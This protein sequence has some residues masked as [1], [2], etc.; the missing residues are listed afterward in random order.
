MAPHGHRPNP[1]PHPARR[2]TVLLLCAV[3]GA[4]LVA[5]AV[6]LQVLDRGFLQR[7]GDLRSLRVIPIPAHRGMIT[8]RNGA[9]LAISTPMDSVC[10]DPRELGGDRAGLAHLAR[11]LDLNPVSLAAR[12]RADSTRQFMYID[13]QIP[14]EAG[15]RAAALDLPGVFL[16]REYKSYYPTGPVAA[17][18]VGF[19]NIDNVGQEGLELAYNKWL[20]GVPG[21][22]RV[23]EDRL[24]HVVQDVE[25]LRAPRPGKDLALSLD[26][27]IQYLAYRELKAT[28]QR[29]HARAGSLAMLDVRTGE[30]L[31]MVNQPSYNP[32]NR[33]QLQPARYRN[34]AVTDVFEPGSAIKPFTIA[35]ALLSGR[36]RPD[37]VID[38]SPGW[39]VVGG[40]TIQDVSDFGTIDVSTVIEKSSNVGASKIAL[41]LSPRA[42]WTEFRKFGFGVGTGSGFPGESPGW[43]PFYTNW[44]RV[45]QAHLAFGYGISVTALQLVQAYA[46]LAD[47]GVMHPVRFTKATQPVSGIRVLP[48]RIAREVLAMMERV[49]S[50]EGTGYRARV[51]GYRVAGKTGTVH[52][53]VPGGYSPHHYNAIFA[54]LAPAGDPRLAMVVVIDD[55]QGEY[56]GGQVAAPLFAKVMAG[57]LRFLDIAPDAIPPRRFVW[58]GRRA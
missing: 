16:R 25:L 54:G 56:Y 14:P 42:L 36:Y 26:R 52:R 23:L 41:S 53:A 50:P 44:N 58:G 1:G 32:N 8:D 37:T 38:T 31:A 3:A 21:S 19:T 15:R 40:D 4:L 20:H 46:A 22:E 12:V 24:G 43:L 6:D 47:D 51:P 48:A 9:P 28:V 5:R 39:W 18:V 2:A 55:P 45:D 57:A 10:A 27:R 29:R 13:R 30:V 34:R 49:V 11:M 33:T 17:Q 35:T 7:Q